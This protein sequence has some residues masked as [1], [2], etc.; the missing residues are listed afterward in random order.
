MVIEK[1]GLWG[2]DRKAACG[3]GESRRK[4]DIMKASWSRCSDP[5]T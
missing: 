1:S 3:F 5:D 2:Q 4:V